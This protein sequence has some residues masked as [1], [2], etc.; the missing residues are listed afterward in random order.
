M[1]I[2]L[3]LPEATGAQ[4][5]AA[6]SR[7]HWAPD[8]L[9]AAQKI[10]TGECKAKLGNFGWSHAPCT[11]CQRVMPKNWNRTFPI[12]FSLFLFS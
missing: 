5:A 10:T 3:Y 7:K 12:V 9:N 4:Q 2:L 1:Q 6:L 11:K 8:S